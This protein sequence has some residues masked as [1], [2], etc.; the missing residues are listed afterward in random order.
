MLSVVDVYGA[1][2]VMAHFFYENG[3]DM[4][5]LQLISGTIY[6]GVWQGT[7]VVHDTMNKDYVV[8][9][10]IFSRS[11]FSK[12]LNIIW[13]DPAPWWNIDWSYRKV[14][15]LNHSQV[16]SSQINFPVVIRIVDTDLK[17]KAQPNGNDIVFTNSTGVKLDHEIE[18]YVQETGELIAWVNVTALSS[19]TDTELF[20]YYGNNACSNQENAAGVWSQYTMVYHFGEPTGT[21]G[22]GSVSD[23][24]GHTSGTPTPGITFG[25]NG[26]IGTTADFSSGTGILC[27]TVGS[28]LLTAETT[29]SF[30]I[31]SNNV[32]SPSRQN[33]FNQA[34]G[35]WGTMTLETNGAISWYYGSN[36]GDSSPYG[37]HQSSAS[38]ITAGSWIYITAVRN[39]NGYTYSWYKNGNFL[40][41]STYPA[42]YPVIASRSFIIGDGYVYP[43]NGRLD[44]FRVSRVANSPNWIKTCYNNQNNAYDGGFFTVGDEEIAIP[45]QPMLITPENLSYTSDTTPSFQWIN[46]EN[47]ENITLYVS[48]ASD[49]SEEEIN[50]T[51][52]PLTTGYTIP[53]VDALSEGRWFWKIVAQNSQGTNS[54]QTWSFIVDTTPPLSVALRSPANNTSIDTNQVPFQ[55]NLTSDN[56]TNTIQVSSIAYYQLQVDNNQDFLS[57]IIDE[58]T[59]DNTTHSLTRIV[60]GRLYWHVRAWD[61]AGNPGGWSETRTL[62]IFSY[63]L[64]ADSSMLQI[65]RG[66]SGSTIVHITHIFGE[67][68]NVSLSSK[69]SGGNQPSSIMVNISTQE[70]PVSFDSTI[71]F[72]CGES[73]STGTFTCILE[74]VSTS[75]ITRSLTIEVTVYN[76]LF[77][78]DVFPRSLSLIRSDQGTAT[79]SVTFDQGALNTV[80]LTGAW[81]GLIP[82]GVTTTFSI[83]SGTPTFD[84]ILTFQTSTSASAG[85]FIY[86]ITGTSAGLSKIANIYIE[87]S[88]DLTLTVTTDKKTYEKGQEIQISGTAKDP[89]GNTVNS[90]TITVQISS[91]NWSHT[92][93]TSISNGVY[94]TSYYI[95]FEK[96]DGGWIIS[97]TGADTKGH[98]TSKTQTTSIS[99]TTPEIYQYY[100]INVLSPTTGQVMKRGD[101]VTFSVSVRNQENEKVQDAEIKAYFASG[102]VQVFSEVTPG[103]YSYS[104]ELGYDSNVG[105]ETVY[106]E[107][108]NF[109]GQKLKVGFTTI[110]FK[111]STV[112]LTVNLVE[113]KPSNLV[114]IGETLFIKLEVLYPNGNPVENSIITTIGP[115]ERELIFS[116]SISEHATYTTSFIPNENDIGK[117]NIH[118]KVEDAYGNFRSVD[119]NSIE[120]VHTKILSYLLHY[121]WVTTLAILFMI[122]FLSYFTNRKLGLLRLRAVEKELAELNSLKQ[123]N[124]LFY[125][126]DHSISRETYE[127]LSQEYETKIAQLSKKQRIFERRYREK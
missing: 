42:T 117:W 116:K 41:G 19:S 35:G 14:I 33:P 107:C 7:W 85:S 39:P 22:V 30:W 26:K 91:D 21:S 111:V 83:V 54:S 125:Y 15:T 62:T 31:Y 96:P 82:S 18:K 94:N 97:V 100:Y 120:I 122:S 69:W 3:A 25:Q 56:T 74:T 55:W 12:T 123:K 16:P 105:T 112:E 50:I 65:K 10:T 8:A 93:T 73:A 46:G 124:A 99:V 92:V 115:N 77:S 90:G 68:E 98:V 66:T 52:S 119:L 38:T 71:T 45:T 59:S 13:S 87:I 63:S 29:I 104:Y 36:G 75:G 17:D 78:L 34:Y 32:G 43:L 4:I 48:N 58:Y 106:I 72:L 67:T 23:S 108:K 44:E 113:M 2:K 110:D 118:I 5:P 103:I 64:H 79:V 84:S 27:G 40:T 51:L 24:T 47:H 6:T 49:F 126:S 101:I 114:E 121:W 88:T 86:R 11:G 102:A 53:G 89:K 80:N 20:M 127:L 81:I 37:G 109:E 95:T 76:M 1:E 9:A 61:K 60:T 28:S 57:P 70:A